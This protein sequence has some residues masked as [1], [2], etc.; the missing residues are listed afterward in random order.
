MNPTSLGS[1]FKQKLIGINLQGQEENNYLNIEKMKPKD[2]VK[3][4]TN[5]TQMAKAK[6]SYEPI[7]IA[8][9]R[10]DNDTFQ[11]SIMAQTRIV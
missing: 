2:V 6:Q 1:S 5:N 8:A 4:E 10:I 11:R 7:D 3:K 9:V